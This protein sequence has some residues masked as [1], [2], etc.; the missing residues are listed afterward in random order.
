MPWEDVPEHDRDWVYNSWAHFEF[1]LRWVFL[2]YEL[3][4]KWTPQIANQVNIYEF[5]KVLAYICQHELPRHGKITIEAPTGSTKTDTV[6]KGYILWRV[7]RDRRIR[8]GLYGHDKPKVERHM[9]KY[10]AHLEHNQALQKCFGSFWD[11]RH[12]KANK[13]N[14]EVMQVRGSAGNETIRACS[15]GSESEGFPFDVI[16]MDDVQ[17]RREAANA[18]QRE[19]A[20]QW[21]TEVV[22]NR[23]RA[24]TEEPD[25]GVILSIG[26]RQNPGDIHQRAREA[27]DWK[28]FWFP[29]ILKDAVV[30]DE[31]LGHGGRYEVRE[32]EDGRIK[33]MALEDNWDEPP[34]V[35][36]PE[37]R[38]FRY[39]EL[40]RERDIYPVQFARKKQNI[41]RD[42]SA[43]LFPQA[44]LAAYCRADGG[45]DPD[46]R[47]K[48]LLRAWN[49]HEGR[50]KVY[51]VNLQRRIVSVD[52][53]ATAK[54]SGRLDPD[55]T[56]YLL[57]GITGR[58]RRVLL[59]VIRCRISSPSKQ[60]ARLMQVYHVYAPTVPPVVESNACQRLW[61]KDVTEQ[62]GLPVRL[63][64]MG[65]IPQ[66]DE[67][68]SF[69]DLAYSGMFLYPWD[70][71]DVYTMQVMKVFEDEIT[72]YPETRHDD[73]LMAL[74]LAERQSIK[75][76][77]IELDGVRR[78]G[79]PVVDLEPT[80]A[81]LLLDEEYVEKVTD[82]M[83]VEEG[84]L[85]V[86]ALLGLEKEGRVRSAREIG[87]RNQGGRRL[88][89]RASWLR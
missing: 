47:R 66:L 14:T 13:W 53:A 15:Y 44:M 6:A 21:A 80:A 88:P 10:A 20:W 57:L 82:R 36:L 28:G 39:P 87:R 65:S 84:T 54:I 9:H 33:A 58:R 41:V 64:Q 29:A 46:G 60:R 49:I 55:Y 40:A 3:H 19:K 79:E 24:D 56:V 85:D 22:Q 45:V 51:P 72:S 52:L 1:F 16:V 17:G 50:P 35:L 70:E 18:E 4:G 67:I 74:L 8:I 61:A 76:R 89:Q 48:P 12:V 69:A 23:L 77:P 71:R 31:T 68:E 38:G 30:K 42:E 78:H 27:G 75:G 37:R 59:D 5:Q 73:Q 11:E 2:P 43:K 83:G 62:E 86:D 63:E 25:L 34:K 26:T 7:V 81:D 32:D